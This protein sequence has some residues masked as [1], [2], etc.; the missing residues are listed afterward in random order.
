MTVIVV[1]TLRNVGVTEVELVV[2][3]LQWRPNMTEIKVGVAIQVDVPLATFMILIYVT[4]RIEEEVLRSHGINA[5]GTV[6]IVHLAI[7]RHSFSH[8]EVHTSAI[9]VVAYNIGVSANLQIISN[10]SINVE[11]KRITLVVEAFQYTLLG[12]IVARNEVFDF[13]SATIDGNVV[14]LNDTG[15]RNHVIEP[16]GFLSCSLGSDFGLILHIVISHSLTCILCHIIPVALCDLFTIA[17]IHFMSKILNANIAI[18]A[19]GWFAFLAMLGSDQDDTV[20]TIGTIDGCSRS[21]LQDFH[22]F[23]V[24]RIDVIQ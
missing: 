17:E 24:A 6:F 5:V 21:I 16:V 7:R 19:Y 11:T 22:R 14:I 1:F 9:A 13:I 8:K 15:A 20:G 10:V 12:Q 4:H 23:D 3:T 2:Q 18:V